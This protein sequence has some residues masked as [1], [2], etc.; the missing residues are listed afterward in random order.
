MWLLNTTT[1]VLRR[2]NAPEDVPGGYA[3]LS[4]VWGNPEEEDTFQSVQAAAITC[5]NAAR[6]R[7]HNMLSADPNGQ[8]S[9]RNLLE[10]IMELRETVRMQAEMLSKQEDMLSG[11]SARVNLLELGYS[12]RTGVS[13]GLQ[14]VQ[15]AVTTSHPENTAYAS[16]PPAV[17]R[18]SDLVSEKIRKFLIQAKADGYDWAWADTC[19]IDKTSSTELTEAI[20]SMFQYYSLSDICY[21]YLSDVPADGI[22][23]TWDSRP[24]RVP[25]KFVASKWHKRG[26]TLQELLAPHNVI[27]MSSDWTAVGDKYNLAETLEQA[28][29]IPKSVLRM[30]EDFTTKSIAARMSWAARRKTTRIEDEAYCMLGIFGVNMPTIYGEGRNAFFRL[31]EE[32]VKSSTDSTFLAW[33]SSFRSAYMFWDAKELQVIQRQEYLTMSDRQG[34]HALA[35]SPMLFDGSGDIK[36]GYLLTDKQVSLIGGNHHILPGER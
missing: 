35:H 18:D 2:F 33:G 20:N 7:P 34:V 6:A 10:I 16:P 27:F 25:S 15:P 17:P 36:T 4:H 29:K 19:C 22:T 5:E 1:A 23:T 28:T 13:Q 11:L 9:D 14:G 8:L 12:P 24:R 3:I 26:W 30:E 31:Q 32:I 21:A